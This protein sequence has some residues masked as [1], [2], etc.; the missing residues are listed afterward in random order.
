MRSYRSSMT[1]D[2]EGFFRGRLLVVMGQFLE[3]I[4]RY[5]YIK[6]ILY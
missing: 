2:K 1:A 3:T 6:L 5:I 4:L